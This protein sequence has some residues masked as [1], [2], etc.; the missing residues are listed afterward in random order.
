MARLSFAFERVMTGGIANVAQV[1]AE[2]PVD[3]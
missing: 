2:V 1:K 3:L